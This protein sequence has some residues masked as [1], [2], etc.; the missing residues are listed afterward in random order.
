MKGIVITILVIAAL[1]VI[2]AS[3]QSTYDGKAKIVLKLV[4]IPPTPTPIPAQSSTTSSFAEAPTTFGF[5]V[6]DVPHGTILQATVLYSEDPA[7]KVGDSCS[8]LV[9][10]DNSN[11]PS[12]MQSGLLDK[13]LPGAIV[14]VNDYTLNGGQVDVNLENTAAWSQKIFIVDMSQATPGES[15]N[16]FRIDLNMFK[17]FSTTFPLGNMV[18]TPT[19]IATPAPSVTPNPSL[20]PYG[21]LGVIVSA[22]PSPTLDLSGGFDSLIGHFF[23]W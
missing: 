14:G 21:P 12:A 13:L 3:V 17:D 5:P 1:V 19:P 2:C 23:E 4:Q 16:P 20:T 22:T 15:S 18:S 11:V 7:L 9:D 6:V 8:L 10:Y